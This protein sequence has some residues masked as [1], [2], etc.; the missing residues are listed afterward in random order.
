MQ[1]ISLNVNS[2]AE[3]AT[4]AKAIVEHVDP[5]LDGHKVNS[6]KPKILAFYGDLGVGKT[7]LI[8]EICRQ[9]GSR[10]DFSSPSYSLVNEYTGNNRIAKIYHID[11]YR[12]KNLDE[13]IAIGIEDYL[14]GRNFCLI[15]WPEV[16]EPLL[17]ADAIR[18]KMKVNND[19]REISIFIPSCLQ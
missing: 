4:A 11:L 12:L 18:V 16:I 17:P 8:K 5:L 14:D 10:D 13:A 7:T 3:L 19:M 6:P 9:I 1:Q 2:L 15:E